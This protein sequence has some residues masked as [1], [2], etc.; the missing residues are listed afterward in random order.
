MC[1]LTLIP[2]YVNPDLSRFKIAAES[3]PDGFGFAIS[4]GKKIITAHGMKFEEVANKFTDLRTTEQG[5]A[6]FHFRWATH[7]T[8]TIDNCHPFT[9]G[10]DRE[11]VLGHNGILPVEIKAGDTR[12]DTKVFAED[13][14]PYVGGI[15]SLDDSD[16]FIR[17]ANWAKGSKLAFLTVNDDAKYDWYII[18]EAN[19][20]WDQDM[21][22]SNY[23]YEERVYKPSTYPYAGIY[24]E[25]WDYSYTSL[26]KDEAVYT[27]TDD[28]DDEAS[29]IFDETLS[30]LNVFMTTIDEHTDLLECYTCAFADKVATNSLHAYCPACEACLFCGAHT[31]CGC[32][33]TLDEHNIDYYNPHHAW[34]NPNKYTT[35][36]P[37][38]Y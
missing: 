34:V 22:W 37:S 20:H 2:D 24:S 38:Y 28:Y 9:I 14:F 29:I 8:E 32:W 4:T 6:I 7:G 30:K 33:D 26:H 25:A 27:P 13:I 16:Y 1:L 17:L 3:N 12:S 31:D 18:N 10:Q 5:P 23:S 36:H 15:A 19:G 11:T 21:W 35:T